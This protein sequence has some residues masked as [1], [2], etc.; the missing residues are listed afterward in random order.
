MLKLP[1]FNKMHI[2]IRM[3][4]LLKFTT[5]MKAYFIS[6]IAADKRIFRH[7]KLPEGFHAVYL[8]WIKPYPDEKLSQ[9]A[10]RLAQRIDTTE[11][12]IL[13]GTSLGG[14]MAVEIAKEYH[15]VAVIIIGSVSVS[16]NL[17]RYFRVTGRLQIHR[18]IPGSFFKVSAMAKHYF[19]SENKEDKKIIIKMIHETDASFIRWGIHAVL[20][21]QNT[22]LPKSLYHI[23]G[24]NDK[25]FPY[26]LVSA[27]HTINNGDHIIV[28]SKPDEVNTYIH[29][30]LSIS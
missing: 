1:Q 12:F 7:I 24:T 6:G 18:L 22:E 10:H 28:V 13:V 29:K 16:D 3:A 21:W 9:Y 5:Q 23:H 20:T 25:M 30:I 11:A 17:P 19:S 27:T 15:P 26:S 2:Y 4:Q 14:I 8:D